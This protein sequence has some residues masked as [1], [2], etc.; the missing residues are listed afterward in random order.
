MVLGE[1]ILAVGSVAE[2]HDK[3]LDVSRIGGGCQGYLAGHWDALDEEK[4]G[5]DHV[6]DVA[7]ITSHDGVE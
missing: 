6:V 2:I 4:V 1:G 5:V 3:E 7:G